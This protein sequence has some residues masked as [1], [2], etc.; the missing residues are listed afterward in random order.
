MKKVLLQK[1]TRQYIRIHLGYTPEYISQQNR[2]IFLIKS[3]SNDHNILP[4]R[5]IVQK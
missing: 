3:F 4:D 2:K 1:S 5:A